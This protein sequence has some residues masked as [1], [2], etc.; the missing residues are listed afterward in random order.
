MRSVAIEAGERP[1]EAPWDCSLDTSHI[2][3]KTYPESRADLVPADESVITHEFVYYPEAQRTELHEKATG[4]KR[5]QQGGGRRG[6]TSST[7]TSS[8]RRR[9]EQKLGKL[10]LDAD[11][12]FV[13]LT[14][15]DNFSRYP[16]H[17][18]PTDSEDYKKD[19]NRFFDQLKYRY[20]IGMVW[21]LEFRKI[22]G[23]PHYHLLIYGLPA[24]GDIDLKDIWLKVIKGEGGDAPSDAVDIKRPTSTEHVK[25]TFAYM[26]KLDHA[27]LSSEY[28]NH[29]GGF[30][31]CK[32]RKNL[33]FVEPIRIGLP[34]AVAVPT[35][36]KMEKYRDE[37]SNRKYGPQ[38]HNPGIINRRGDANEM[39]QWIAGVLSEHEYVDTTTGEVIQ[40]K[41]IPHRFGTG[42][43]I[44]GGTPC[45]EGPV[46]TEEPHPDIVSAAEDVTMAAQVAWYGYLDS[47][48][49]SAGSSYAWEAT[50]GYSVNPYDMLWPVCA[51]TGSALTATRAP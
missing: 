19:L 21:R 33:P 13:T 32:G 11:F 14:Y 51:A 37:T 7:Y 31:G 38:P 23:A 43:E 4:V 49:S 1:G 44:Y 16:E 50:C 5:P 10:H 17:G 47:F 40:G 34:E 18:F 35:R 39:E 12:L 3:R 28:V 8:M 45:I 48:A 2:S 6:R 46:A 24:N 26:A 9:M 30:Y 15:P 36:N 27:Q 41:D 20:N 22:R 29:S 42:Q 25:R